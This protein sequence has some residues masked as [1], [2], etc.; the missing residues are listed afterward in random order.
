MSLNSME[1]NVLLVDDKDQFIGLMKKMEAHEK[2]LLHRAVS[3]FV[4]NSKNEM[5][6]Q[7]RALSKYHTPGLWSNTACTHPRENET[8]K[9]AVQ[10]RVFEEMG[11]K[12]KLDFSF[13][14]TYKCYFSNGLTEHEFDHV[15]VGRTDALPEINTE[16]VDAYVF[17]SLDSVEKELKE[18]PENYTKWFQICFPKIRKLY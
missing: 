2:G 15:F 5:L 9:E 18:N 12:T 10:R 7:K 14:F 13:S 16:E 8:V 3:A 6:L 4:F 1:E 11:I 17:K